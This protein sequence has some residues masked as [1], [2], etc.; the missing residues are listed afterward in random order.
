MK[1]QKLGFKQSF[2]YILSV[3]CY[4]YYVKSNNLVSDQAFDEI[5]KLYCKMFN[6]GHVPNRMDE[7][8]EC[9]TYGVKVVYDFIKEKLEKKEE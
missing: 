7:R 9:Y 2:E 6:E 3:L 1:R 5:E 8:E 4:A